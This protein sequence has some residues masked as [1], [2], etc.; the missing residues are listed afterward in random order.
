MPPAKKTAALAPFADRLLTWF[1]VHGRHDLPWQH[2][3]TPY[4]V[5]LSEIMLQQTQVTTVIPYFERFLQRFPDV[6][7]L[8]AA[9]VDDVLALW[10]GLGYYARARNLHR[11]AQAVVNEHGGE[12]PRDIDAMQAMPGIGRSTAGA[13]LSQA[14]GDRH[15]ILDGNVRRVLSRHAAVEGWPGAPA[16]QKKLWK[17]SESLLP[18]TRMADY[19]QAIMDLGASLCSTRKPAC[20]ICPLTQDCGARIAGLTAQ[21]PGA[22]PKPKQERPERV[23]QVLLIEN[24]RG[25]LLLERRPPAGIWGGLWCPPLLDEGLDPATACRERYALE[26]GP[27]QALPPLHHAF[28]HFDLELRPLRLRAGPASTLRETAEL[29]WIK[30]DDP[31]KGLP[32]PIRKLL[33]A[34]RKAGLTENEK[35][36][37][38]S[39]A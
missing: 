28:S 11:C 13:I 8:A 37:E 2:P 29:A 16:V 35:C 25:E 30:M 21:I 22:K 23:T 10:A 32:A 31:T 19:T 17:V 26:P 4:R 15:A 36:P 7:S 5:W 38:P 12:F 18:Q 34:R 6:A 3:R 27:A 39:T 14:H 24:G 20:A 1:D 33:D 9:P